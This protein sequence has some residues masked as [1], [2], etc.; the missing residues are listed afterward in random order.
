SLWMLQSLN[1]H[2]AVPV[3]TAPILASSHHTHVGTIQTLLG[4]QCGD[5]Q[6]LGDF[7]QLRTG[8]QGE[9]EISYADSN[10]ISHTLTSHAMF[11]RQKSGT[12]LIAGFS[13]IN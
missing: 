10:N 9:A 1:A 11:V 8:A 12:V 4:G 5:R 13:P 6:G 7:L 3:F 2:D